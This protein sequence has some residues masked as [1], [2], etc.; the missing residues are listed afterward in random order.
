MNE[1]Q[2]INSASPKKS[3]SF[4][5]GDHS[6]NRGIT[7]RTLILEVEKDLTEIDIKKK[8]ISYLKNTSIPLPKETK[9]ISFQSQTSRSA[10]HAQIDTDEYITV[11]FSKVWL[12]EFC[13]SFSADKLSDAEMKMRNTLFGFNREFKEV[14]TRL[15]ALDENLD[16]KQDTIKPF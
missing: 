2:D 1:T 15:N 14:N 11:S 12:N 5:I 16:K 7:F 4:S 10:F 6:K 13:N 8:L 3:I 9:D